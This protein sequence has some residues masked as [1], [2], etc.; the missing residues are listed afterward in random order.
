MNRRSNVMLLTQVSEV[1]LL[2][3]S[4]WNCHYYFW[5]RLLG[6]ISYMLCRGHGC[7][8]FGHGKSMLKLEKEGAPWKKYDSGLTHLFHSELYVPVM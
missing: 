5:Y 7:S 6:N 8:F 1:Y 3:N 4:N 2:T